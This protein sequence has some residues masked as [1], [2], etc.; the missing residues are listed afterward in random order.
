M[1]YIIR[2][3]TSRELRENLA[4]SRTQTNIPGVR[5]RVRNTEEAVEVGDRLRREEG[6]DDIAPIAVRGDSDGS[7]QARIDLAQRLG[8]DAYKRDPER[9]IREGLV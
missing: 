1:V 5:G 8:I 4:E 6:M 3:S 7:H 2:K 9:A